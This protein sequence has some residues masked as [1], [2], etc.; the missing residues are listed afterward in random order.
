MESQPTL[1][2]FEILE[3]LNLSQDEIDKLSDESGW[4]LARALT[5]NL[6]ENLPSKVEVAALTLKS[7]LPFKS[8]TLREVLIH[9]VADLA[10]VT[11]QLFEDG[12]F[13]PA[14]IMARSVVETVSIMF[15]L[16]K[17]VLDFCDNHD[18]EKLD[19]FLMK[20]TM[21]SKDKSTPHEPYNILTAVDKVDKEFEGLRQMYD[22]LSEFAHPNW[23]GTLGAYGRFDKEKHILLFDEHRTPKVALGLAPFVG[24]LTIFTD[25]YNDLARLIQE[26]NDYFETLAR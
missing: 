11:M 24:A 9:R 5:T 6:A 7:K 1:K 26:M 21:G 25:Y 20:T 10:T 23:S 18:V 19:E 14:F 4:K 13:V 16:H 12:R 22:C 15:F 3:E 8:L 2:T 17:S